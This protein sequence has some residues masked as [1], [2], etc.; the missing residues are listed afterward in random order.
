MK[1]FV[2]LFRKGERKLSEA[3]DKRRD[4]EVKAWAA[5]Q[6]SEGRALDPRILGQEVGYIQPDAGSAP[7]GESHLVAA[8][9][10][11]AADFAEAV[12]I[13]KT[14]PGARYGVSVEVRPWS[15]PPAARP[16]P[17]G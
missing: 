2:F 17:A 8:V 5:R 1:Q 12:T 16:I 15:S 7:E 13:A 6:V 14:H 9:F 3:E 11:K 10:L 4:D